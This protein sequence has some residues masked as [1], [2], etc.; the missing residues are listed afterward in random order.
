[1]DVLRGLF[2]GILDMPLLVKEILEPYGE[3]GI[4][5]VQEDSE[6]FESQ[7]YIYPEEEPQIQLLT[8]RKKMEWLASRYLLHVMSGRTTRGAC[9]KDSYGKPYLVDSP[10]SISISHSKDLTAVVASP[11]LVGVDIQYLVPKISRIAR[12]FVSIEEYKLIPPRHELM[13]YHFIWGA[14]ESLY[15]AYGKGQLNFINHIYVQ[16]IVKDGRDMHGT[17]LVHKDDFKARFRLIGRIFE[18]YILVYAIHEE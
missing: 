9:L 10:Y 17:A 11:M 13:Y 14:K 7:L 12:K 18:E 16:S 4:W 1:M 6:F 2:Y 8:G 15:K 3:L 5:H